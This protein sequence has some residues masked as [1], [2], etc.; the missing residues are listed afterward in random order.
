MAL[1]RRVE[2]LQQL[3]LEVAATTVQR[4][5]AD[6]RLGFVTLT[7]VKLSPDLTQA[8][9]HWSCLGDG[10]ARRK[11][12][13]ALSDATG[14]VQAV[15]AKAIGT[16]TT[17]EITFRYDPSLEKAGHLE[18]IFEKLKHEPGHVP[19]APIDSPAADDDAKDDDDE[20]ADKVEDAPEGDDE[21]A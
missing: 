6:P 2:R 15:V 8:V 16:R 20:D 13:R 1:P 5:L 12:A 7:R 4:E 18:E 21:K 14:L 19:A 3:I 11:S 9:I 17:P 10:A